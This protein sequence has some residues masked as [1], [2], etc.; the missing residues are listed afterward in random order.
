[1]AGEAKASIGETSRKI[2][3][4]F[5]LVMTSHHEAGHVIYALL[6][7]MRVSSVCVYEDKDRKRIY[8]ATYY[9]HPQD[10]STIQ[11]PELLATLVRA[12]VGM[13]YA[14]LIAEKALFKSISGS[15]QTPLFI[16]EGSALDNKG[17]R[18]MIVK[19]ALAPSGSKRAAYKAKLMREVRADLRVYWR[20]VVRLAHG[21]YKHRKLSFEDLSMLLTKK[22]PNK[23][24][25]R[26]RFKKMNRL[27]NKPESSE[28]VLCVLLSEPT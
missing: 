3:K 11:D 14:G 15:S 7:L 26:E 10:F 2:A 19:Y 9:D 25:W 22:S 13:S 23:K 8:G 5:E 27:Y 20:D 12:D 16:S 28:E 6:H 4:S 1:M 17:A 21:L 24:F 18:D